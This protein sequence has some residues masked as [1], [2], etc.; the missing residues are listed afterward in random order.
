MLGTTTCN[1]LVLPQTFRADYEATAFLSLEKL[2]ER[3]MKEYQDFQEKCRNE[4]K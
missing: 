1:L 4:I 3:Q 2:K